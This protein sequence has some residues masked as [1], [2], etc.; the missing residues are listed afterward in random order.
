MIMQK[1]DLKPFTSQN[2]IKQQEQD[3]KIK[4]ITN[5][6]KITNSFCTGKSGQL[7][8]YFIKRNQTNCLFFVSVKKNHQKSIQ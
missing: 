1:L 7:L 8:R 4:T 6:S 2:K 5:A 3:L